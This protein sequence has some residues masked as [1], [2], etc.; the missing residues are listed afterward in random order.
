MSIGTRKRW[1]QA[2]LRL[3]RTQGRSVSRLMLATL[4]VALT[5]NQP[6][7]AACDPRDLADAVVVSLETTAVCEPVCEDKY[8]CYAAAI[9]GGALT[10]VANREG[11][12]RV[13]GFCSTV[14]G[15]GNEVIGQVQDVLQYQFVKDQLGQVGSYLGE[16]AQN[17]QQVLAIVHCGCET[18]RLNLKNQ[19]SFGVCANEMLHAV[20]CGSID[21]TT[22][23]IE[24][25]TPGGKLIQDFFNASWDE[26]KSI[27]CDSNLTSWLF[28]CG[29][30]GTAGPSNIQCYAGYQPDIG[31][32]CHRCDATA[33]AR[34]LDNGR[35]GCEAAYT[36]HFRFHNGLPILMDCACAAPY[37]QVG[38]RCLCPSNMTIKDGACVPCANH[39]RY[40]PL[41]V[42]NGVEQLPSCQSCALGYRQSATDPTMCVAGWSCDE[43]SGEVPDPNTQGRTCLQCKAHQRVVADEPIYRYRCENCAPGQ[44]ASPDHARC[45]AECPAGSI[46]NT[47][48]GA[49]VFGKAPAACIPCAPGEHAVYEH[50]GSSIG[51][52]ELMSNISLP[53]AKKDCS[54]VGANFINDPDRPSRC[55]S[56][57]VGTQPN[58][59]RSACIDRPTPGLRQP[60]LNETIPPRDRVNDPRPDLQPKLRAPRT[61]CPPN[62]R[63]DSRSARCVPLDEVNPPQRP[64]RP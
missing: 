12:D 44:K 7:T 24:S 62:P 55:I 61:T 46:T 49:V 3:L 45:V 57:P 31:G 42:V 21:F 39:E 25:C 41:R 11:Q 2:L 1:V 26:L 20:G 32:V 29:G 50:P 14:Q 34:A 33:H 9:L 8:R 28:N 16:Y 56:C 10:V 6:A 47:A 15:T 59:T 40:V 35:C 43:K 4:L 60:I 18:E 17:G 63:L 5:P 38:E 37:Q 27:G 48:M 51:R 36:P 13:D 54:A 19:T 64:S 52:C 58:A 23:V 53:L 22:G 30:G